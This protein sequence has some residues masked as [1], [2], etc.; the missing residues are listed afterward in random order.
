MAS[1][2]DI[3]KLFTLHSKITSDAI[4]VVLH[5]L[6]ELETIYLGPLGLTREQM[7]RQ[8]LKFVKW[9]A[10]YSIFDGVIC[11]RHTF[12]HARIEDARPANQEFEIALSNSYQ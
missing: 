3:F 8:R 4:Q 11:V 7:L 1:P 9:E 12:G 5:H 6:H 2:L 10:Y